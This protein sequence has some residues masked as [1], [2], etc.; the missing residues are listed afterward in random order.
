M[1]RYDIRP[2]LEKV[3]AASLILA[4]EK[5][6]MSPI[7]ESQEIASLIKSATFQVVAGE[8]HVFNVSSASEL[9]IASMIF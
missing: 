4:G 8:G 3:T 5:D 6:S 2:N 7:K 9:R 1:K